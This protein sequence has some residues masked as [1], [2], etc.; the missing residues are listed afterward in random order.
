MKIW[1]KI[2]AS[3]TVIAPTA[4]IPVTEDITFVPETLVEKVFTNG[5]GSIRFATEGIESGLRMKTTMSLEVAN[6]TG[7][8]TA[9]SSYQVTEYGLIAA[10]TAT[11][12]EDNKNNIAIDTSK[13]MTQAAFSLDGNKDTYFEM[14]DGKKAITGVLY[15]ITPDNYSSEYV[16]RPYMKYKDSTGREYCIYGET[17][18]RTIKE[19]AQAALEDPEASPSYTDKQRTYLENIVNHTPVA[20]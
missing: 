2:A 8:V 3:G 10:K 7:E 9:D 1:K 15:S 16:M 17:Q 5:G 20:E 13:V 4:A 14:K 12:G 18:G 11:I 19:V 6:A